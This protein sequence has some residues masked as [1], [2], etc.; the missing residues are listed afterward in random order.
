MILDAFDPSTGL[1]LVQETRVAGSDLRTLPKWLGSLAAHSLPEEV[2]WFPHYL[3]WDGPVLSS[4]RCW[5]CGI[6]LC[7]WRPVIDSAGNLRYRGDNLCVW[8]RQLDHARQTPVMVRWECLNVTIAFDAMH[9]ADCVIE[10][11]DAPILMAIVLSG[12]DAMRRTTEEQGASLSMDAHAWATHLYRWSNDSKIAC[13]PIG[14][15]AEK[16]KH[17]KIGRQF[18]TPGKPMSPNDFVRL[19][20]T[21]HSHQFHAGMVMEFVG[22]DIPPGWA[23]GPREGTIVKR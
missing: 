6:G 20:E 15:G 9:C 7:A 21:A 11:S 17:L 10:Q 12:H 8:L 5:K 1:P 2:K 23:K 13:E 18:P 3:T 22:K 16:M 14:V 19:S 4:V